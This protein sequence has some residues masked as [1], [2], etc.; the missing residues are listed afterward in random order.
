MRAAAFGGFIL[1]FSCISLTNA[2]PNRAINSWRN[3]EGLFFSKMNC[4]RLKFFLAFSLSPHGVPNTILLKHTQ[5]LVHSTQLIYT[6]TKLSQLSE[7]MSHEQPTML[8]LYSLRHK[9]LVVLTFQYINFAI[10]LNVTHI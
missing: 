1:H 10:H 7:L 5:L 9:S 2:L 3:G 6:I 8:N 4:E